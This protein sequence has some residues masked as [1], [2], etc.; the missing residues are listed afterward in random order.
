MYTIEDIRDIAI[1]I[2]RNGERT[3]RLASEK[4]VDT[5]LA[6]L[7]SWMADEE[8]RHGGWFEGFAADRQVFQENFEMEAMGRSLLREMVKNQTFSLN[9]EKLDAAEDV[10]ALLTQS[11]NFE[12]DTIIFYNLIESFIDDPKTS[13]QLSIIVEEERGHVNELKK[14]KKKFSS[15]MNVDFL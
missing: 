6:K 10:I 13:E 3:Y 8:E 4:A 5:E 2:E 1:Q 14:L 12:K 15:G 11:L 9:G 7:L